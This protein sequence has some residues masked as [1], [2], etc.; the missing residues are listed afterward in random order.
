MR[1]RRPRPATRQAQRVP[2]SEAR[3]TYKPNQIIADRG[4]INSKEYQLLR[5]EN[6]AF[7]RSLEGKLPLARLGLAGCVVLISIGMAAYVAK[8]QPRV[9]RNHA[10]AVAI[11]ALLA[12]TLLLAQLAAIGS[13]P[14]YVFGVAPSVLVA[15]ILAI[16]YEQR[17]AVGM[18]GMHAVLVTLALDA[19]LSFL[20]IVWSGIAT[21]CFLLDDVRTRS[22]LIEVGGATALAM[23]VTTAAAGLLAFDPFEYI[24]RSCLYTGAAGLAVGF[25]V[26]GILPFIEKTFRI[27]TSMTL[28]ELADASHPLLRRLAMEAPGTYNHSLQ[29]ASLA[30]EAAEAIAANSLLCRV[31]SYYHDVGKINKPEYFIENQAGGVNRHLNLD[32]NL[33]F[34]IIMGHVKDGIELAK[35]YNLP[36]SIFPFIQQHHGTTLVEYF[37]HRACSKQEQNEQNG[38]AISEVQYRYPGPKPK[39]REIAVVMLADAVESTTRAMAEPNPARIEAVVH[40][41]AMKRLLERA[42]RRVRPD[43]A[44]PGTR[45]ARAGED[46]GRR[47]PRAHRVPINRLD[48]A[49]DGFR[50]GLKAGTGQSGSTTSA[51]TA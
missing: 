20:L 5:A 25:V 10:R 11:A 8:V 13:S 30:E 16:A 9:V 23:I 49:N 34:L 3:V 41:L 2:E 51:Q 17:F 4:E 46:A 40:D 33:S 32:P 43:D 39:S 37:Y 19:P 38:P 36:T 35:E 42:V 47:V 31:A 22:K 1:R 7:R 24:V 12:A 44:R 26:L 50:P 29:V 15:M 48:D 45:R 27:T 14:L 6:D 21:A 18:A 28:L